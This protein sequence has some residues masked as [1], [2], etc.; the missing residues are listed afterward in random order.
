MVRR[1]HSLEERFWA[2]VDKNGSIFKDLGPC[3]TWTASLTTAGYGKFGITNGR[4]VEAHRVAYELIMG[5]VPEGLCL[6][7][8]CRNRMCVNPDHL[9][10]VTLVENFKR[11][12]DSHPASNA[13]R[14]AMA[15]A[16]THCRNGHPRTPP[17]THWWKGHRYCRICAKE[18]AREYRTGQGA[19]PTYA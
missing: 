2:K 6:D 11:G 9:E 17:N 5:P 10:P 14:K 4:A 7:H 13:T 12:I 15:L 19:T 3:W 1:F 16:S 18:R 8:L